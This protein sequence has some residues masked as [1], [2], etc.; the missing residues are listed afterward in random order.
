MNWDMQGL[1]N[2]LND[3]VGFLPNLIAGLVV[4][5]IGYIIARVLG[6]VT[7]SI[8]HRVG[9][10]GLT[11]RMGLTTTAEPETASRFSGKAVFLVVMLVTI[12]Q[13]ARSWNMHFVASGFARLIAYIPHLVAAIA[14]MG[15]ALWVGNWVRER[16]LRRPMFSATG[17]EVGRPY[18]AQLKL[19]PSVA[20]GIILGLGLFM[21]LREL[22]IAPEI[23]NVAFTLMLGA[24]AVAT[25]LAFGLGGRDVAGRIAQS[26]YERRR[27]GPTTGPMPGMPPPAMT[28]GRRV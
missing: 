10:D 25:A 8:L 26:W 2:A 3:F 11:S 4:L 23:V 1:K 7:R 9:F 27:G 22:Q 18:D 15:V 6:R 13:V 21:G 17:T 28:G 14:I 5:L 16:L 20:R 24:I 19:L 12:M